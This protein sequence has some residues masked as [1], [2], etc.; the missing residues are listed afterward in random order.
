LY[1]LQLQ[2]SPAT[3]SAAA[4]SRDPPRACLLLLLPACNALPAD[5][6]A[7]SGIIPTPVAAALPA[8]PEL[9]YLPLPPMLPNLL[10]SSATDPA[11]GAAGAAVCC[12]PFIEDCLLPAAGLSSLPLL[13]LLLLLLL[14]L[15]LG[16]IK[17]AS[18]RKSLSSTSSGKHCSTPSPCCDAVDGAAP[19][20]EALCC[21][22]SCCTCCMVCFV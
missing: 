9:P 21:T 3:A 10:P 1:T 14:Q 20:A 5:A 12:P 2:S 11:A 19:S 18:C 13:L 17:A 7:T 6:A 15:P 16:A 22:S 4:A 8:L